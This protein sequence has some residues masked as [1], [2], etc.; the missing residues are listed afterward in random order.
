MQF[1]YTALPGKKP[2]NR[3]LPITTQ[4]LISVITPYFNAGENFEST[5]YSVCNQ[6]FPYFEWII[7]DDDSTNLQDAAQLDTLAARDTR[8]FVHHRVNEL[9]RTTGRSY[10]ASAARNFGATLAHTDYLLFLDADDLID[11]VFFETMYLA[12]RLEPD[13]GWAYTDVVNFGDKTLLWRRDFSSDLMKIENLLMPDT[14]VR[15]DMFEALGGFATMEGRYFN[16]DWHFWLRALAKGYRPVHVAQYLFWYRCN[17]SG[18]VLSSIK[19]NEE[20]TRVNREIIAQAA[21]RVPDGIKAIEYKSTKQKIFAGTPLWPEVPELPFAQ[22]KTHL[23]FLLPHLFMGGSDHFNLEF[24]KRLDPAQYELTIVTT[25][26]EDNECQHL[27]APYADDIFAIP[28][29]FDM[30]QWPAFLAYLMRSRG[31]SLVFCSNSYYGYFVLPWLRAQF[32]SVPMVDY[33]HMEEWYYRGGGY[34]RTTGNVGGIVDKTFVC[35]ENT[36][37]VILEQFKRAPESVRTVYIG[38]DEKRFD[39]AVIT[40]EE[41]NAAVRAVLPQRDAHRPMVLFPCRVVAQKRPFLMLEIARQLPQYDFA[42]VGDGLQ[43]DA[44]RAAAKD[45]HADNVLFA[46]RQSDLRPWYRAAAVT[47]ICSLREGL[48]LTAYESLSMATPVVTSSAGGQR[49]LVD[50]AVGAVI[51]LP[52]EKTLCEDN[53][54]FADE[55]PLYVQALTHILKDTAAYDTMC[56]ACR[57]R[58]VNGFTLD[59]MAR[60]LRAEFDAL[61]T[62]A[63]AAARAAHY[64]PLAQLA[65]L[66]ESYAELFCDYDYLERRFFFSDGSYHYYKEHYENEA[67]PAATE[68]ARVQSTRSYRVA[69][70]YQNL[71]NRSPVLQSLRRGLGG[72]KHLIRRK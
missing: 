61:L 33:V 53:R 11:P 70:A 35:N 1:D 60:T 67:L 25:L 41:A 14:L 42:V 57:A 37:R 16:E 54:D 27:F 30:Q 56:C 20:A 55:A 4:P 24:I 21:S 52:Y 58:I 40:P 64:A 45:A 19:A 10:G 31:I 65:P 48:S 28:F 18:G 5:F 9:R 6:T 7:V 71:V 17:L 3:F 68:L 2:H 66:F 62:P 63:A 34:A 47:L 23:L 46:G 72:I 69:A 12:L 49:E 29:L 13:A 43:E 38:V 8:I 44:L 39:A 22:K 26:P 51:P 32:P 15:K 50:S 59:G 36:R